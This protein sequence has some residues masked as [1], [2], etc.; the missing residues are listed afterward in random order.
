M[1]K[2]ISKIHYDTYYQCDGFLCAFQENSWIGPEGKEHY[3]FS[4]LLGPVGKTT[5]DYSVYVDNEKTEL[6]AIKR[7]LQETN[8]AWLD[9]YIGWTWHPKETIGMNPLEFLDW[10][11]SKG[12]TFTDTTTLYP[13]RHDGSLLL[14]GNLNEF[15]HAFHF[16]VWDDEMK[17]TLKKRIPKNLHFIPEKK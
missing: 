5:E 17:E 8:G 11:K 13:D 3:F 1:L 7:Q 4:N 14:I 10:V 15:S 9:R 6:E 12:Y 2:F 16:I